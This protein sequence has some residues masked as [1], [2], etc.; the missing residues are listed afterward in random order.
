MLKFYVTYGYGSNLRDCYSTVEAESYAE[1]R[2][3]IMEVTGGKFAFDYPQ[4]KYA[5]CIGRYNM[6]EVPLQPQVYPEE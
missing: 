5:S 3:H 2:K 4:E 6:V 1:A